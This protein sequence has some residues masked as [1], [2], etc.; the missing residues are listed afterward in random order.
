MLSNLSR[1]HN[2][3]CL[4]GSDCQ[5]R[6]AGTLQYIMDNDLTKVQN[7]RK[8]LVN[9]PTEL[10][11]KIL[12]YL[13]TSDKFKTRYI[14]RRFKDVSEMPLL[15]KTFVW[16]DYEPRHV[17]SVSKIL[18]AHG[19]H[20]RRISFPAHLTP[21]NI[22]EMVWCCNKVTHLSLPRN[23]QLS[24]AHLEQIVHTMTQLVEMDVFTSS[25]GCDHPR[26]LN[27]NEIIERF[28]EVFVTR[29][30]HLVLRIDQLDRHSRIDQQLCS[31]VSVLLIIERLL[32]Q[33]H[34]L[35]PVLDLFIHQDYIGISI[36]TLESL[37][38]SSSML[39]PFEI[40]LY[41]RGVPMDLYP[42][43]P[44]R[45]FKFGPTAT[46]P[47]I[48]LSDY[49]IQGLG[50]S[51]IFY[52]TDYDH[53]GKVRISLN[54][55]KYNH[56]H[57]EHLHYISNFDSVSSVDFYRVN[58]HPDH[59]EQLA[60][61]CPNLE[62]LNL[63]NAE[64]CLQSLQGLRAIV[65]TCQ[66]LQGLNLVGI[67]MSSVESY[68]LLW[69]LLSS[70]KMLT[71]LAIDL[72]MLIQSRN[73]DVDKLKLIHMLRSCDNLKALEMIQSWLCVSCEEIHSIEDLLFSHFPSLVYVRLVHVQCTTA[74][75]YTITN[76]RQLKHL[77][78]RT[79]LH[80]EVNVTLPSSS[81]CHLQELCLESS[82]QVDLTV[83]SVD[84]LSAH[85]KLE[86][87][88]LF[89]KSIA[90]SAIITLIKNSPNLILLYI[91]TREPLCDEKGVSL[92]RECYMDTVS[93]I[94][95]SHKLMTTGNFV[96]EGGHSMICKGDVI[97]H[98]SANFKSLWCNT[99]LL[100]HNSYLC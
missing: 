21:A 5:Y 47:L 75:K 8:S 51:D 37:L 55:T 82:R 32:D 84:V 63:M 70:I 26:R 39:E 18:K 81:S 41:V 11:V 96:V 35:P 28:M 45:K 60:V 85:G 22:L 98:F 36:A 44:L 42:F 69:K 58:I 53:Y 78:Y 72:C 27:H 57:A 23:I 6:I 86:Q 52:A 68:L 25:I 74:L 89:V 24:L 31:P 48:Q 93:K 100:Q 94:F 59:L 76:C 29:I 83:P 13:P 91:V 3:Y 34:A 40:N 73:C 61:A 12:S 10:L 87:V 62:R 66:N 99:T 15:W 19:K 43:V 2:N 7:Y 17:R 50:D 16:P 1:D 77:S 95:S 97:S 38:A 9:L 64:D 71:H 88:V 56:L 79:N 90:T 30:K 67:P 14:S 65:D 80:S 46:P 92:R 33:G 49:G 20:V 54:P 4:R